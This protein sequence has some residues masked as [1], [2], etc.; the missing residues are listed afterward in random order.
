MWEACGP[1]FDHYIR[2][3]ESGAR[4]L[5]PEIREQFSRNGWITD[6]PPCRHPVEPAGTVL[7]PFGGAGTVALVSSRNNRRSI[8]CELNPKYVAMAEARL[9]KGGYD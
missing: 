5:P 9:L 8:S 1:A 6:A 3:D 2:T 7:D 4:P